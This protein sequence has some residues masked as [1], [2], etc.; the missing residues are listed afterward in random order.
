MEEKNTSL[1]VKVI[2]HVFNS[3]RYVG[4]AGVVESRKHH[5]GVL[6]ILEYFVKGSTPFLQFLKSKEEEK[7]Q[8]TKAKRE[9]EKRQRQTGRTGDTD[10]MS[11]FNVFTVPLSNNAWIN[12]HQIC[13]SANI[14]SVLLTNGWYVAPAKRK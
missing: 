1:G 3:E 11:R 6:I 14:S 10:L 8:M 5:R 4:V 2:Q 12:C 13:F 9:G 7:Y